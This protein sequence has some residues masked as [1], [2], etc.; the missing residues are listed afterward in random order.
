MKYLSGPGIPQ[1]ANTTHPSIDIKYWIN[2]LLYNE[3]K[4]NIW[5]ISADINV[6]NY[7]KC[8]FPIRKWEIR[9][10]T[11]PLSCKIANTLCL[12]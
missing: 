12:I 6:G 7:D 5:N 9:S 2:D 8:V 4:I 3:S 1:L 11:T 10:G